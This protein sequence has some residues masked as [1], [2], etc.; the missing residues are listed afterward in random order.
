MKTALASLFHSIIKVAVLGVVAVLAVI[1]LLMFSSST[2][3]LHIGHWN[4]QFWHKGWPPHLHC[5]SQPSR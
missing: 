1:L 3:S 2:T 4:C 5:Q